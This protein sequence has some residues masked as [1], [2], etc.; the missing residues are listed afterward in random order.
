MAE[1][2]DV[3][4]AN[5]R[6]WSATGKAARER[7]PEWYRL[8]RLLHHARILPVAVELTPQLEAIRSQRSLLTNPNP[9]PPLLR[10]VTTA[11]RKAVSEAH[12]CLRKERGSRGE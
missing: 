8:E 10:K 12:A 5:H 11:L 1:L 3:L 2:A 7:L 9:L 4:I 6:E